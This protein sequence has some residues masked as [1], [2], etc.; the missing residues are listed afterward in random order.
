METAQEGQE[1][2]WSRLGKWEGVADHVWGGAHSTG[3][4]TL[5]RSISESDTASEQVVQ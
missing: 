5:P 2:L 3:Y 1:A 4:T